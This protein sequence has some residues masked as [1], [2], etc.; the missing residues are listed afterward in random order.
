MPAV[1]RT[2]LSIFFVRLA[3]PM[4]CTDG[5]G[6][7]SSGVEPPRPARELRSIPVFTHYLAEKIKRDRSFT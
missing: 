2:P 5:F 7:V 1:T 4:V 6:A 3:L